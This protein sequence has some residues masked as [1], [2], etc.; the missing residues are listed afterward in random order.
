MS[1]APAETKPTAT[2]KQPFIVLSL[3]V[4]ILVV[5]L[6]V[7]AWDCALLRIRISFADEQIRIFEEMRARAS[8]SEP[9][10]ATGYLKYML[11]Y[12]P[13]G[14]KQLKGSQLDQIV[15]QS[16]Q[17]AIARI[18]A[19]VRFRTGSTITTDPVE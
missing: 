6:G 19:D 16:R 4:V 15:E 3:F 17:N 14:T 12:Y 2:F 10:A 7:C 8:Q 5:L 11:A 13:S 9:G 18:V 1:T